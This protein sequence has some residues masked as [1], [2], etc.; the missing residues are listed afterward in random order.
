MKLSQSEK[1]VF[2][3]FLLNGIDVESCSRLRKDELQKELKKVDKQLKTVRKVL[4]LQL[5]HQLTKHYKDTDLT[6]LNE[7]MEEAIKNGG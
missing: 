4:I 3:E 6:L 5:A 2:E 7:E 1:D